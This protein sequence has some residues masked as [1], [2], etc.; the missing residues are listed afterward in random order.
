VKRSASTPD[1][2]RKTRAV[3]D[4]HDLGPFAALRLTNSTAPFFAEAK[5]L[6]HEA[7]RQV[8]P[9]PFLEVLA[10]GLEHAK[11]RA[12]LGPALEASVAGA[13]GRLP[14]GKVLA[15]RAGAK[16]LENAVEH[17]PRLFPPP[18]FAVPAH[19]GSGKERRYDRPLNLRQ[20]HLVS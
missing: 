2:D 1:G 4:C 3:R 13:L 9:A 5:A 15:R 8:D 10:Q 19:L 18:S 6:V 17:I 20:I 11:E 16:D 12:V 7:L 14:L